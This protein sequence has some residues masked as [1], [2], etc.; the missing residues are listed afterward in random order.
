MTCAYAVRGAISKLNGV[1]SVDV[2][3]NKG[4]A[5]IQL[6]E[7]NTLGFAEVWRAVKRAGFT[8]KETTVSLRG[9]LLRGPKPRLRMLDG[10]AEYD[11]IAAPNT[12]VSD[13]F[14]RYAGKTVTVEG[15][16]QPIGTIAEP[17]SISVTSLKM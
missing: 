7:S 14:R 8:P 13:E 2:S 9:E 1:Q 6:K 17:S 4:L 16:T 3:L 10:K 11:L 15:T 12:K 5:A